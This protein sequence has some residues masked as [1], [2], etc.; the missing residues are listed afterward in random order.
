MLWIIRDNNADATKY[1]LDILEKS[2]RI[3]NEEVKQ[4]NSVEHA[5]HGKKDDIYLVTTLFDAIKILAMGRKRIFIWFQGAFSEES[6]MKHKSIL[7]KKILRLIEKF[8]LSKSEFIFFVSEEMKK[9]YTEQ[10]NVKIDG[11]YYI[12]PCFNS[13]IV[14]ESFYNVNKYKNNTFCYA[15]SLSVWQGIDTILKCYKEI[16]SW[17]IPD[18]KLLILTSEKQKAEKLIREIGIKNYCIDYTSL[19]SLP[20]VL[21]EA[22][23]GFII[24]EDNIVNRV[25]TPT[26]ISTYLA[27][28]MIPIYSECLLDFKENSKE[29][30]YIV[31]FDDDN[32]RNNVRNFMISNLENDKIY[33]NF[34]I[35]FEQYFNAEYHA[36]QI[37]KKTKY[38]YNK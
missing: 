21:S 24:R 1:Y 7:R 26:K 28:G 27:N 37:S 12:M 34:S 8:I 35:I 14:E 30:E 29:I 19:E 11:K 3:L 18:T 25:S 13:V 38:I 20:D 22:K 33:K 31:S 2:A 36:K 6:Y 23:F 16:E 17:G 5:K 15:G 32:F 9:Y 4:V 10:F